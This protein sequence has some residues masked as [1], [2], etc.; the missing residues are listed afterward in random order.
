A[1]PARPSIRYTGSAGFPAGGLQF[2]V[3]PFQDPQGDNSF[4]AIQWRVGAI[5]G[6]GSEPWNYEIEPVWLGPETP[7]QGVDAH[8]PSG[9]CKPGRTYRVRARYKDATG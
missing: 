3:S 2:A 1:I 9:A 7:V 4:A 5:S 8:I 6:K